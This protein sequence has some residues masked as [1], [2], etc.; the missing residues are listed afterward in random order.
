MTESLPMIDRTALDARLSGP[1]NPTMTSQNNTSNAFLTLLEQQ[2]LSDSSGDAP[3]NSALPMDPTSTAATRGTLTP[4]TAQMWVSALLQSLPVPGMDGSDASQTSDGADAWEPGSDSVLSTSALLQQWQGSLPYVNGAS[5]EVAPPTGMSLSGTTMSAT[6]L[7]PIINEAVQAASSKY[8]LPQNLILAVIDQESG[9]DPNSVSS[10][11]AQ[12]LMQ[13]MPDTAKTL[14]V[15]NAFDPV[16]NVDAG[17]RYLADMVHQFGSI[18]L[19][20]AA[21]N[22]GPG[23]VQSYGGIP[24][25][26][27]TQ[28]YVKSIL[29]KSSL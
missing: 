2:M 9:R 11:G 24:P 25:Y 18:P 12:G 14:G 22:A 7:N 20:L 1:T 3:V 21:Y 8:G 16:Q 15:T 26:S 28:N 4:A 5:T 13:L 27:E 29:A 10:A 6:Q 23:A 17:T 19:G